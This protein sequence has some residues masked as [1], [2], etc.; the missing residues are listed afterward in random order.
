[1][2]LTQIIP[3]LLI[4]ALFGAGCQ[5]TN[6][7]QGANSSNEDTPLTLGNNN[8]AIDPCSLIEKSEIDALFGVPSEIIENDIEPRNATGQKLCVYDVPSEDAVTMVQVTV[9]QSKD[10]MGDMNTRELFNSQKEFLD[11]VVEVQDL[12]DASYQTK[13]DFVGGGALY[14]L[15][16]N[17]SVLITVD[18]SLG[19]L[20]HEAN[21]AAEKALMEKIL[22]NL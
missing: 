11:G 17:E 7:D 6:D 8:G 4:L 18:V 20:D 2:K 3:I 16:K 1:M 5:S 13:M 21:Q 9:Q 10:M 12:G 14:T 15:A 22:E 19:R